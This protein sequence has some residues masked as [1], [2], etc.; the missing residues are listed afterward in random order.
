MIIDKQAFHYHEYL[1]CLS[2][3]TGRRVDDKDEV[4][5][6]SCQAAR[7]L[8]QYAAIMRN[9][10]RRAYDPLAIPDFQ[11]SYA[12]TYEERD[13]AV[14]V[15]REIEDALKDSSTSFWLLELLVSPDKQLRE[16]GE[17]IVN[18]CRK[19]SEDAVQQVQSE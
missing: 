16:F 14:E 15:L 18:I 13:A 2:F 7:L 6:V 17:S 9:I 1:D 4:I 12:L 11:G 10:K 3:Y 19:R 8:Q 5:N